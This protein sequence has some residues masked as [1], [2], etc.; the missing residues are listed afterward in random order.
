MIYSNLGR[1]C[2]Q[3]DIRPMLDAHKSEYIYYKTD[4]HWT[5]LGAYLGYTEWQRQ[6]GNL[7]E[8]SDYNVTLATSDFKGSLLF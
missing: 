1:D 5:T 4:H 3:I 7:V 6:N 8:L 2:E